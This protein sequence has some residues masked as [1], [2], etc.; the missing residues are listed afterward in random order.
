MVKVNCRDAFHDYKREDFHLFR[1]G[2][3]AEALMGDVGDGVRAEVRVSDA[4]A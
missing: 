1:E 3:D 2:G 4:L